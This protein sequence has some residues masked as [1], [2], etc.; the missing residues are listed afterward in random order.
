MLTTIVAILGG[1]FV[2]AGLGFVSALL[3]VMFSQDTWGTLDWSDDEDEF[4]G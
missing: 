1:L 4:L 2:V 3:W